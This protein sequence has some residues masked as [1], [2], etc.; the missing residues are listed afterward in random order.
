MHV[1]G[2]RVVGECEECKEC[3]EREESKE[4]ERS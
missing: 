2:Q 4:R 1:G 3:G